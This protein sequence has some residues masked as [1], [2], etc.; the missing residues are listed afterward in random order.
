LDTLRVDVDHEDEGVIVNVA[1]ELDPLTAETLDDQVDGLVLAGY[2]SVVL[3]LREVTFLDSSGL[4]ALIRAH[5]EMARH[6]RSLQLRSPSQSVRRV[7]E[8][9]GLVD[10]LDVVG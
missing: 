1:G 8:L 5:G 10:Y 7:L 2:P 4:R 6:G 3:D 9:T